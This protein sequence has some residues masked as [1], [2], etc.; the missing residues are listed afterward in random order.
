M[1]VFHLHYYDLSTPKINDLRRREF[2]NEIKIVSSENGG[3]SYQLQDKIVS[4]IPVSNVY[5]A[6]IIIERYIK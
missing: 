5:G 6:Q 2:D 4:C 3:L 1:C